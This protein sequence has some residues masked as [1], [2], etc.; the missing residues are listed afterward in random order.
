M[1]DH[2]FFRRLGELE[3][4][5]VEGDVDDRGRSV[6]GD[7]ADGI[8]EREKFGTVGELRLLRR[9]LR[10]PVGHLRSLL[11]E[12]GALLIE[13]RLLH[14][15]GV[16]LRLLLRIRERCRLDLGSTG[17][18]LLLPRVE[19]GRARVELLLPRF[20]LRARI[21]EL[22]ATIDDLLSLVVQLLLGRERVGDPCHV[23]E[24]VRGRDER[25]DLAL[26]RVGE[27]RPV[28]GAEDDRAGG[29]AEV[30]Q[31]VL[32]FRDDV[33]GCRPGDVETRAEALEP[34]EEAAD[35]DPQDDG[36][37]D[38]HGPCPAGCERPEA[39]QQFGHE[40]F[41]SR[42]AQESTVGSD[43]SA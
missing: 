35:H 42:G 15:E 41:L 37:G 39:V 26:L 8:R 27:S 1:L 28:V 22:L 25:T 12:R 31:L 24:I 10:E 14:V 33:S 2:G 20:R 17:G 38:D 3:P 7:Q 29:P 16:E 11:L 18:E 40:G 36:P 19:L 23:G 4:G 43:Q 34:D 32:E 5:L 13:L 6:L 21:R 30:G 9:D